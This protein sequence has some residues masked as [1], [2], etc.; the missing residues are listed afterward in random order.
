MTLGRLFYLS[1][2]RPI[3]WIERSI[4]EG[5]PI[6]QWRDYRGRSAMRKVVRDLPAL[7]APPVDAP[8]ICFL[9]GQ[10]YW[11]QTALCFWSLRYY[12]GI[13]LRP[14][15]IDDGTF[16]SSLREEVQ[17]MFPGAEILERSQIEH[18]LDACLPREKFP[19]LRLQRMTYLHLRKLT[20]AHAGREGW[21]L[22]LDSDMLFFHRPDALMRWIAAPEQPIHML[23][24]ANAY[25]YPAATLED[26]ASR[27]V[28]DRIN[29]GICGL[30]SDALDWEKLEWWTSELLARHGTSYYLEQALTALLLAG[31]TSVQLPSESYLLM[32]DE[33]ECRNPRAA[34]HHYVAESKRGYFRHA[35]RVISREFKN[36]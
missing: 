15:L 11:Y 34:M 9:T 12:S 1:Y 29:V 7:T 19:M 30:R 14:V 25:G 2:Y 26:L 23:D 16:D 33:R 5:G 6:E 28:P 10:K 21:R 32:P 31:E 20:D 22:V 36:S 27:K 8:E 24:V 35:W 17:R 4:R 18:A 3:G 13:D